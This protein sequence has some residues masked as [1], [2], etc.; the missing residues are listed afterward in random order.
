V[1]D[2][3]SEETRMTFE[4]F[5]KNLELKS[6]CTMKGGE[7]LEVVYLFQRSTT[8]AALTDMPIK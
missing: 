7:I 4:P 8:V 6:E 2:P 1:M 3:D 5:P